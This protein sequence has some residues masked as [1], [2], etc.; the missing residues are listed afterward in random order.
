MLQEFQNKM[1]F[2]YLFREVSAQSSEGVFEALQ[3]FAEV[4]HDYYHKKKV[5]RVNHRVF[6]LSILT[7]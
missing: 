6:F 4:L 1:V 7:P 2:D 3:E 5:N